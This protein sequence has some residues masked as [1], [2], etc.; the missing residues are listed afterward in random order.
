[1]SGKGVGSLELIVHPTLP[2]RIDELLARVAELEGGGGKPPKT[3]TNSSLPPSRGQKVN[4]ADASATKKSRK[5]RRR[6]A[7]ALREP[8]RDAR[9]LCQALRLRCEGTCHRSGEHLRSQLSCV[10][11]EKEPHPG[12]GA[13]LEPVR[14]GGGMACTGRRSAN[15][16]ARPSD[17]AQHGREQPIRSLPLR[18][19]EKTIQAVDDCLEHPSGCQLDRE[20]MILRCERSWEGRRSVSKSFRQLD[21]GPLQCSRDCD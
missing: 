21:I 4:V 5:G 17:L 11:H 20:K 12:G 3:P 18:R 9:H 15:Q 8:R 19:G 6:R 16:P 2:A 7:R 14:P 13:G 1:M 10:F